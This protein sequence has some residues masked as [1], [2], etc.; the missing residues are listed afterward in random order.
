MD[1][2]RSER[3]EAIESSAILM[4]AQQ[5]SPADSGKTCGAEHTLTF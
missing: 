1:G 4:D 3:R 5:S 2:G